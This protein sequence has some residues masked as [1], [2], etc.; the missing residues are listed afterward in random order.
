MITPMMRRRMDVLLLDDGSPR[1]LDAVKFLH[2]LPI[3]RMA[4]PKSSVT[5]IGIVESNQSFDLLVRETILEQAKD[6]LAEKGLRVEAQLF[7]GDPAG[8]LVEISQELKPDLVMLGTQ[9]RLAGGKR[10]LGRPA[11]ALIGQIGQ[12]L[13]LIQAP[14]TG[15]RRVFAVASGPDL[16]AIDFLSKFPLPARTVVQVADLLSLVPVPDSQ[17]LSFLFGPEAFVRSRKALHDGKGSEAAASVQQAIQILNEE[18]IEAA[19][20]PETGDARGNIETLKKNPFDLAVVDRASLQR[21]TDQWTEINPRVFPLGDSSAVMI[22]QGNP[23][24]C[25][26]AIT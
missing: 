2:D 19:H 5:L 4:L 23:Q 15:L 3:S 8:R 22:V 13:L 18:R 26:G 12:P 1:F 25:G 16:C 24:P 21:L 17:Q 10:M 14:Y 9:R 6:F 7:L 20:L 11:E